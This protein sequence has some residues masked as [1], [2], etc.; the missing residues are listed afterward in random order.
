MSNTKYVDTLRIHE[1]SGRAKPIKVERADGTVE[2]VDVETVVRGVAR[3][4]QIEALRDNLPECASCGRRVPPVDLK[5]PPSKGRA[6]CCKDCPRCADCGVQ[7]NDR[8]MLGYFVK[9]RGGERPR[10]QRCAASR[11]AGQ[12]SKEHMAS[13]APRTMSRSVRRKVASSLRDYHASIT[14]EQRSARG[15]KANATRRARQG[16]A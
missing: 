2:V 5:W 12:F 3:K 7:V 13:L 15:R 10:C 4:A 16:A 8:A 1:R 9:K 14:Q 11:F 6:V